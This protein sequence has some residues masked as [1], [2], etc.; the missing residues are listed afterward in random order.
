MS[1]YTNSDSE[2][3]V[4]ESNGDRIT[5]TLDGSELEGD[6]QTMKRLADDILHEADDHKTDLQKASE[7][8][9]AH[10]RVSCDCCNFEAEFEYASR[11]RDRN[12]TPEDHADHP[13]FECTADD[14]TVEAFCPRHGTIPLSYDECDGC[15]DVRN[16]MNR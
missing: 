4:V 9:G 8:S 7:I 14:V 11:V 10:I 12:A 15:A 3:G 13:D 1:D 5:A 6:W 16:M 2:N